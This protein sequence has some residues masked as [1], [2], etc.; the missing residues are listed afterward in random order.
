[1]KVVDLESTCAVQPRISI[2]A[3][4]GRGGSDVG[5]GIQTGR[6]AVETEYRLRM[7]SQARSESRLDVDWAGDEGRRSSV[8]LCGAA[9]DFNRGGAGSRRFGRRGR[10]ITGRRPVE[11]AALS[12]LRMNSQA[13]S[14]SRLEVD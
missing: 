1:M 6:R 7:N 10:Y 3:A 12:R 14:E 8:D 4:L 2:V 13:R 5:D 11:P 9:T